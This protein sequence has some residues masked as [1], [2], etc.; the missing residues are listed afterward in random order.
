MLNGIARELWYD[1]LATAVA[2][3]DG[4]LV[5]FNPRF[6][7]C[8][9]AGNALECMFRRIPRSQLWCFACFNAATHVHC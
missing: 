2:E 9:E 4:R 1:N 3:H 7:T 6:A 8:K 5:R